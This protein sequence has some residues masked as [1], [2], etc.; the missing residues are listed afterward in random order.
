[1][2]DPTFDAL[3]ASEVQAQT[4]STEVAQNNVNAFV[5]LLDR[6]GSAILLL[7]SQGGPYGWGVGDA[8]PDKVK[9]IIALEPEGPPFEQLIVATGPAR[10]YGLTTLPITYDPP[11]TDP[12]TDL[13]HQRIPAANANV[14]SCLE[15]TP[16]ARQL[17]ELS[18]FPMLMYT[19]EASYHALY[20]YCTYQYMVDAGMNVTRLNL[21]DVGIHGN[22][23]FSFMEKNN[24]VIAPLLA[25]WLEAVL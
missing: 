25:A 10:P 17:V 1:M 7:H 15:Q 14:S 22:G 19:T 4:N 8:R 16:P 9:A 13:P 24:L 2:G 21:P 6:I 5:A 20:D 11:V 23:H 3:Y 18:K 12:A